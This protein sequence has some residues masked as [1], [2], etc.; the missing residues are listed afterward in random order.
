ME[1]ITTSVF[2]KNIKAYNL[3]SSLIIN[4][5]GT[6]SSKTYSILQLLVLI[7]QRSKESLIISVVS[8][9]LP[10]LRLGAMRDMDNILISLGI[11]PD[12]IKNKTDCYYK[13][14]RSII[15][16]F[17][18][19]QIDKV[20]G[21]S[22]DILFINECNYIKYDI[23]D[24]LAIRTKRVVFL[25][26]NPSRSFWFHDEIQ[27]KQ[28]YEFIKSTYLDNEHLTTQQIE[29]IE[30]KKQNFYWWQVYGLGELGRLE[31]AIFSNWKYGKFD[32]TL[33]HSYGL[34]FGVKDPDALVKIAIDK[35]NHLLYWKQEIYQ[36]SLSTPE[37]GKIIKSRNVGN[38]L[39][40]ADNAGLRT[41]VDLRKEGL[42]IVPVVKPRI[43]DR[44]K[45]IWEY[46]II[47]DPESFDL[48]REL[49]N[50]VWL[51][52]KGEIPIDEDN[53]LIDAASYGTI[54]YLP[55]Y[56][57]AQSYVIVA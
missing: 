32:D 11:V 50:Y 15:E 13:I 44:I 38:S 14:G 8:R 21:P 9:A 10:H 1:M 48:E 47:V 54:Y 16:F 49:N 5:G 52:K 3:G 12:S 27:G 2:R 42:N 19:D 40:V 28:K 36:N 41:I 33:P 26:Y 6:R 57:K 34:D 45:A 4:Q 43:V 24:Q 35:A 30:A 55:N 46:Q 53:H 18:T 7:A 20:H 17:G 23:Y 37:L 56:G 25:D 22:R 29:R 39:I 51:D 31:G